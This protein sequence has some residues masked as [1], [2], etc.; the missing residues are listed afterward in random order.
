M[1]TN[2]N[3]TTTNSHGPETPLDPDR[4]PNT[5]TRYTPEQEREMGV[6]DDKGRTI[7]PT[8]AFM[9]VFLMYTGVAA[10]LIVVAIVIMRMMSN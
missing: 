6:R 3:P 5:E 7:Q 2:S 10:V 9:M 4:L 8:N 1:Q